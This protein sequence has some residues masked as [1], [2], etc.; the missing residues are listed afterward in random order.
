MNILQQYN[1][2]MNERRKKQL[3]LQSCDVYQIKE[4]DRE[5]WLTYNGSPVLPASMIN[6]DIVE[7]VD[8]LRKKF[9]DRNSQTASSAEQTSSLAE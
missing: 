7:Q 9:V 5:L 1:N 6:G 4:L 8:E 3:Q 2:R